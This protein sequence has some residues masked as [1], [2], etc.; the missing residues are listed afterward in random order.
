[1]C[2]LKTPNINQ[3]NSTAEKKRSEKYGKEENHL[4]ATITVYW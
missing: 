2:S 3:I 4:D 1:V